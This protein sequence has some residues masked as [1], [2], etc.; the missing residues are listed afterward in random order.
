MARLVLAADALL[1]VLAQLALAQPRL[2]LTL[3]GLV[4]A[5]LLVAMERRARKGRVAR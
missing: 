5:A 1:I 3:A 4:V 2:A